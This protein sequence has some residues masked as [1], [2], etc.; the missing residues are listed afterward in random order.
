M[1]IAIENF[2]GSAGKN[3]P[4]TCQ[5]KQKGSRFLILHEGVEGIQQRKHRNGST[6]LMLVNKDHTLGVAGEKPDKP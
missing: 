3:T 4:T 2:S 1:I 6:C 5:P